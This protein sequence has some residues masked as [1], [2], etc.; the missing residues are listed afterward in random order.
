MKF[1]FSIRALRKFSAAALFAIAGRAAAADFAAVSNA[2]L[3]VSV[4]AE[5]GI[6]FVDKRTKTF[7]A[8]D[9][10]RLK[11]SNISKEGGAIFFDVA[12]EIPVKAEL[13]LVSESSFELRLNA[14][15]EMKKELRFPPAW[16]PRA[17]DIGLY[18]IGNGYAF[19]AEKKLDFLRRRVFAVSGAWWSMSLSGLQRGGSFL[20]SAIEKPFDAAIYNEYK[21]GFTRTSIAWLP[22]KGDFAYARAVRYF[23]GGSL[24]NAMAQYRQYREGMGYVKTLAQ[25]AK[26]CPDVEK[27]RG[28]ADVWL[29]D[30]NCIARL[31]G[32]A[33][34][35]NAPARDVRKIAREMKALG[36]DRVLWN[37][38]EGESA[39]DCEFLKS[40][41]FLVGKYDIYRDVLPADIAHKIIPYRVERSV[42][43]KYWPHIV[44]VLENGKYQT[45]WQVHGLDGKMYPQHSV[46]EICAYDLT[47]K[48][49]P[50]DL[51]KV[52]YSARLIDVQ[53]GTA[54]VECY[55]KAH[56]ATRA[57][58]AQ[59]IRMQNEYLADLGLVRGVEV[60]HE[61]YVSSYD[62]AEGMTSPAYFRVPG[63]GRRMT[64][65][66]KLSEMPEKTFE[67]MLNPQYRIPMFELAYHDCVVNYWYWGSSSIL[68]PELARKFDAFCALYGYP[69][70]YSVDVAR[71][72]ALKEQIA[73]SYKRC[74]PV[75]E[76]V[77]FAKMTNFEYLT[78]DKKVQRT[79]FGNGYKVVAN[80]S[81]KP[82][83]L[84]GGGVVAPWASAVF[85]AD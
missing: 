78:A 26:K 75:A 28:A 60:G 25:K 9:K 29:W 32:R 66:L 73:E 11:I 54:L 12:A 58:G 82:F 7:F 22:Q 46:C 19:P 53:A 48:N 6:S 80:F 21:D 24:A 84:P 8:Q 37:N 18:P 62:Y 43:T 63:A 34:N 31:Y 51:A 35:P 52:K 74:A 70:I 17:G 49:V 69:P 5:G 45:A 79:T 15:G 23:V 1:R 16:K 40:L 72:N 3:S 50:A 38:F 14:S 61:I 85:R 64:A 67:Y 56:P 57:Q 2:G 4:S 59:Y 65:S 30:E 13:R 10:P 44:R 47:K 76:K 42:N 55:A 68:C 33:E 71:W 77:G 27:L 20:I 83:K 81:E 39:Q 36:M 41:G